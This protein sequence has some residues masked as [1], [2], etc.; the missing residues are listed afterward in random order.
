[1]VFEVDASGAPITTI[2][3]FL[4][5]DLLEKEITLEMPRESDIYLS[6]EGA[7][8]RLYGLSRQIS[9]AVDAG[10]LFEGTP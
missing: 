1:M 8:E 5:T 4:R 9:D 3:V 7:R 10:L 2:S 6:I